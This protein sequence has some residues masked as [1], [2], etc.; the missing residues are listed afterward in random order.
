MK[1]IQ[2]KQ[3]LQLIFRVGGQEKLNTKDAIQKIMCNAINNIK[4]I[5]IYIQIEE[6]IYI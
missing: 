5:Y 4:R 1:T 6:K 3:S 2:K